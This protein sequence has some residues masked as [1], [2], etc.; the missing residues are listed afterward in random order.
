M[1]LENAFNKNV[2]FTE[3][4]KLTLYSTLLENNGSFTC[5]HYFYCSFFNCNIHTFSE[6]IS[7][8]TPSVMNFNILYTLK[9]QQLDGSTL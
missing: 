4:L 8:A 5:Y 6:P 1:K 3:I 2:D 9:H 7:I